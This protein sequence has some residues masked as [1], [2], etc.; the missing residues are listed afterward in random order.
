MLWLAYKNS[1]MTGAFMMMHSSNHKQLRK[2]NSRRYEM[3]KQEYSELQKVS[4]LGEGNPFFGKKHTDE[5]KKQMSESK[6]GINVS[7]NTGLTK[8]NSEKLQE[9]GNNISK[10]VKG[11]RHWTNGIEEVKSFDMPVDGWYI[12]RIPNENF[13]HSN[14]RKQKMSE[15]YSDGKMTWWNNGI[16][17][18]RNYN[19]PN[20]GG[21]WV[22]GRML[23]EN[24]KFLKDK[25]YLRK[26]DYAIIE[27]INTGEIIKVSYID[28]EWEKF[29][30]GFRQNMGSKGKYKNYKLIEFILN[31]NTKRK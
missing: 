30:A 15:S 11:M 1:Q 14:E 29:G 9:V 22:A 18:K 13:K 28:K 4:M 20:D 23:D 24:S 26:Y 25:D 6:I 10:A 17:N 7:W 12:G 8:E 3:L 19:P 16:S 2:Y 21:I 27:D 5:S 31:P